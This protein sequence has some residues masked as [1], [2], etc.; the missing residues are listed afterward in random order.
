M[1]SSALSRKDLC[2]YWLQSW[3]QVFTLELR[4]GKVKMFFLARCLN[5]GAKIRFT[6]SIW[7]HCCIISI[8]IVL[9]CVTHVIFINVNSRNRHD[10]DK[11]GVL[12]KAVFIYTRQQYEPGDFPSYPSDRLL[13]ANHHRSTLT[14]QMTEDWFHFN[15]THFHY[16]IPPPPLANIAARIT[17][18]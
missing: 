10:L 11:H 12:Q 7:Q 9:C 4:A 2:I 17:M 16:N 3:H 13:T 8:V 6:S 14:W 15:V 5:F 1:V 18:A